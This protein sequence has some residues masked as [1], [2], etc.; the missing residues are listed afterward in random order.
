ME[1]KVS[2][3]AAVDR[4]KWLSRQVRDN[5]SFMI[6]AVLVI[7]A[8]G[9]IQGFTTSA[10]QAILMSA[11]YGLV[12][13]GL[14]LIMMTGNIDLSLGY[15]ATS[16]AVTLVTVFNIVYSSTESEAAALAAGL[17]AAL[18]LGCILGGF[19]GFII[20]KIG[21]SP[22]IATIATNYIY[23]GYVL[24]YASSSYGPTEKTL[25]RALG[26]TRLLGQKWLTPMLIF[27]VV[28]FILV[29]L[30]MHKTRF[31]NALKLIGDNAE[32][33]EFAGINS[34]RT[35]FLTYVIAGLLCGIAGYLMVSYDGYA[36]YSQGV[37]LGTLPIACC[38]LG[39]IKMTGGKG[40]ALHIL[41]GV[42]VLRII[43]L[44]MNCLYLQTAYTNLI[45][46]ILLI[47]ILLIDRLTSAK[48]AE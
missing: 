15:L 22:L 11:E 46:G 37:T 2:T 21:I 16:C 43:Y 23:N 27:V 25:A 18:V 44:I 19:N 29:F 3:S 4:S 20:T 13:L 40:T 17:V 36:T 1:K 10:Y 45:T 35:V 26:K 6:L 7:I 38:V 9:F 12:C 5:N 32:A 28:V 24:E 34:K 30:W 48:G 8:V 47:V 42:L 14:G 39:G 31:G 33:A 41:V